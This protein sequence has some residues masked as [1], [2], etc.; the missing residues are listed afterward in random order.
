MFIP[1]YLTLLLRIYFRKINRDRQRINLKVFS[2]VPLL[3]AKKEYSKTPVIEDWH[4]HK[5]KRQ[6][7]YLESSCKRIFSDM[8]K[9]SLFNAQWEKLQIIKQNDHYDPNF[10]PPS[11]VSVCSCVCIYA[12]TEQ[13]CWHTNKLY[14]CLTQSGKIM[15]NF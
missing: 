10:T 1:F 15:G 7:S 5:I 3:I 2:S 14:Q 9:C 12:Q 11:F 13:N 6:C 4:G 8:R